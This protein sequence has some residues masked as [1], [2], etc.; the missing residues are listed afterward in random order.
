MVLQPKLLTP[1]CCPHSTCH[2][3][4]S[5]RKP[6]GAWLGD[7]GSRVHF[8]A[9]FFTCTVEVHQS[10]LPSWVYSRCLHTGTCL[11]HIWGPR[12]IHG[13]L[14][15]NICLNLCLHLDLRRQPPGPQPSASNLPLIGGCSPPQ[16]SAVRL[17]CW[18][19]G[20]G[21]RRPDSPWVNRADPR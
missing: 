7:L 4:G 13:Q 14:A 20:S 18:L 21:P 9:W 2:Y 6:R 5:R 11:A 10:S 3:F 1:S 17:N 15:A 8:I 16:K 12:S 19:S